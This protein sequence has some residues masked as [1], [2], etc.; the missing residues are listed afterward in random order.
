M[1]AEALAQR[2]LLRTAAGEHQ[3]QA[4]VARAGGLEGVGQQLHALL[5]GQPTRVEDVDLAGQQRLGSRSAGSKRSRSTPR[6]QRPIVAGSTPIFSS[7]SSVA[8]LGDSTTSQ[9]P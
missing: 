2:L 7:R 9:A 1:L 3:V 6:S 8:E 5:L 4:R